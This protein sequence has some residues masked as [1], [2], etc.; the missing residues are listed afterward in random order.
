MLFKEV[1][2]AQVRIARPTDQLDRIIEFYRDGLGLEI[3]GSFEKHDGYD[4][5]MFGMPSTWYHLEFTQHEDGSPCPAPTRDNLLV[6]Y[7]PD[8]EGRDRMVDRLKN[9]GYPEVEAENPYWTR[10]GGVTI[11]DPDGWRI[12]LMNTYGLV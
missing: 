9:M 2:V 4:G 12:V 6:F 5:V 8:R 10:N 7:V 11:E 1:A 3:V